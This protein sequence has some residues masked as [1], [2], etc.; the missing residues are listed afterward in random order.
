MARGTSTSVRVGRWAAVL[1]VAVLAGCLYSMGLEKAGV[2]A[3]ILG[4]LIAAATL[5]AP[6]LLPVK[7]SPAPGPEDRGSAVSHVDLRDA[8]GVQYNTGGQ[9]SQNNRF[10]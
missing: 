5:V 7:T 1:G 4:V 6:Y 9:N 3:G 2:L 8:K 10:G